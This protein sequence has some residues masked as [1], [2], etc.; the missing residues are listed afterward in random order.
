METVDIGRLIGAPLG[1]PVPLMVNNTT[2][3][4]AAS[5][6]VLDAVATGAASQV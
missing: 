6:G 3:E 1:D 4:T 2:A 5:T